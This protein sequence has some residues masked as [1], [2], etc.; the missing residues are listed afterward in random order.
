MP[1][2]RAA[3]QFIA[4]GAR[5]EGQLTRA[6][7]A[8]WRDARPLLLEA[9]SRGGATLPIIQSVG[10]Q[11]ASAGQ[12]LIPD[13]QRVIMRYLDAQL[14]RLEETATAG[15]LVDGAELAPLASGLPAWQA[16]AEARI[17]S[18]AA[19]LAGDAPAAIAVALTDSAPQSA[20]S[21]AGNGLLLAAEA[22]TWQALNGSL[23][24]AYSRLN[25]RGR[26]AGRYQ[27]QALAAIDARTT[28]CCLAVHGQ[29]R[30]LDQPFDTPEKPAF[31]PQQQQPPFHWRCRTVEALYHP[32]ME[33]V[34]PTTE[35]L[36]T[37]ASRELADR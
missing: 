35:Q 34:G 16:A 2:L 19:Q 23:K 10:R 13:A 4:A 26:S 28:R 11:I 3:E 9:L 31:A 12:G 29:I 6:A 7:A 8:A 20:Y 27:K 5:L 18:D 37:T 36:V 17:R 22:A 1:D 25:T 24:G 30:D 32:F 21:W 33:R 15:Q 14:A